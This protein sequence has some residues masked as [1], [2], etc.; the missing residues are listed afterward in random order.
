MDGAGVEALA[1]SSKTQRMR[2]DTLFLRAENGCGVWGLIFVGGRA[3]L[4]LD[5]G[6]EWDM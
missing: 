5:L 4:P 1:V 2:G 3:T 6:P